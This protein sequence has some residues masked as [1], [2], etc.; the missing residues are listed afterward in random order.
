VAALSAEYQTQADGLEGIARAIAATRAPGNPLD[1]AL[2]DVIRTVQDLY[3]TNV[4]PSMKVGWGTYPTHLGHTSSP[5]CFRCHDDGHRAADGAV[6]SGEC[7]LC[8]DF[9]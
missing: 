5:G 9:E 6:I 8:H 3:R 4:F 7:S 1:P 2:A